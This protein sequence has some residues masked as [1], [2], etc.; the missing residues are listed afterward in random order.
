MNG[1]QQSKLKMYLTVRIFL[2]ANPAITAKLPNFPEFM[3]ALDAAILQIQSNS[4]E[5]SID[6]SGVTDSKQEYREAVI[7][8]SIDASGKIQ[9]YAKYT[10]DSVLLAETKF[11][12]TDLRH[13]SALDLVDAAS[14][15]KG[16]IDAN[17]DSLALYGLT[18]ESQTVF[19]DAIDS[20]NTAI[21]LPRQSQLWSREKSLLETQG[22]EMGDEAIDHIDSVVEIV[23]LTEPIF[24]IGYK[25][26]RRIIPQGITSL[27][28]QG[29]VIEAANGKPIPYAL[30]T[31][32]L[33]GQTEAVMAKETAAKG[34]FQIKSLSEGVYDISV[35][36]V[37]F[38]TQVVTLT[39]RWDELC[40]VDIALE[41]L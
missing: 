4:Q 22:F 1:K 36:K 35:S 33:T 5:Q 15:L 16:R 23:R 25:N 6:S 3:A 39:V 13:L 28:V 21:P 37:G 27:Q 31:F 14:G 29:N 17:L 19:G 12:K 26:A 32:R 18:A 38:I 20:Y 7:T 41:K 11:T 2:L 9:A 24:Y 34:R 8:L 10:R 30:L 40:N